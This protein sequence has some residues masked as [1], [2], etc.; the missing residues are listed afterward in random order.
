MIFKDLKQGNSVY[1]L[2]RENF[3]Y[4]EGK[5]VFSSSPYIDNQHRQVSPTMVI[6]FK[7]LVEGKEVSYTIPDSLFICYTNNLAISVDKESLAKEI[8]SIKIEAENFLASVDQ[9]KAKNEKIL[10]KA[11]DLL[12][13]LNPM[14]KQKIEME[15][16]FEKIEGSINGFNKKMDKIEEMLSKLI[17]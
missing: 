12:A 11:S 2:D 6:D 7:I 10:E 14:F 13:E 9:K 5:V 17:N 16:R 4:K 8:E 1:I 3:E 15:N